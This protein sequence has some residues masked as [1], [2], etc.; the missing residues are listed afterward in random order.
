MT[1]SYNPSTSNDG[2]FFAYHS[3]MYFTTSDSDHDNSSGS[4]CASVYSAGWWYNLCYNMT[5]AG[6][7]AGQVYWRDSNGNIENVSTISMWIR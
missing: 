7:N 6:T 4:N 2:N 1:V 5:I 3:G